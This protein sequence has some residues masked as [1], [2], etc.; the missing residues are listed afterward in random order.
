MGELFRLRLGNVAA[1]SGELI[2]EPAESTDQAIA[3]LPD[4]ILHLGSSLLHPTFQRAD[5]SRLEDSLQRSPVRI[6]Q[7]VEGGLLREVADHAVAD[8]RPGRGTT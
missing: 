7:L 2:L 1:A 8:N 4:L 5:V 6:G 3:T